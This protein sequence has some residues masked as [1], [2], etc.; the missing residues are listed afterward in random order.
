[1]EKYNFVQYINSSGAAKALS[2]T[3]DIT[4][5]ILPAVAK[6][7]QVRTTFSANF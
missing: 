5:K 3:K 1:M 7:A 6:L 2:G 4:D